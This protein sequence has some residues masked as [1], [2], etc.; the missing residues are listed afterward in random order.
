MDGVGR[1]NKV[2]EYSSSEIG[3]G[4]LV[5]YIHFVLINLKTFYP[6]SF[7]NILLLEI[8]NTKTKAKENAVI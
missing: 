3:N 1:Y 2:Q 8:F 4:F 7:N 5:D 6:G